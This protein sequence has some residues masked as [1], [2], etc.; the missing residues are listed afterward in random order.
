MSLGGF[1]IVRKR[2]LHNSTYCKIDSWNQFYEADVVIRPLAAFSFPVL[3]AFS[4]EYGQNSR[5][6]GVSYKL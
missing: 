6:S 3:A 5:F 4:L 2:Q 1:I